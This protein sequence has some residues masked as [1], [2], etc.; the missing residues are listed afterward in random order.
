MVAVV[1]NPAQTSELFNT[2]P[3]LTLFI[4]KKSLVGPAIAGGLWAVGASSTWSGSTFGKAWP[5]YLKN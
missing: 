2:Q 3:M 4:Q 5:I 1:T